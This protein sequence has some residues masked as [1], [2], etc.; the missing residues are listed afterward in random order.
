MKELTLEET[1]KEC[2]KN[3]E[4]LKEYKRLNPRK[5]YLTKKKNDAEF[6]RYM[7]GYFDFIRDY[8]HTPLTNK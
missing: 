6:E 2:L 8:I 5:I 1:I 7:I 4:L 3:P